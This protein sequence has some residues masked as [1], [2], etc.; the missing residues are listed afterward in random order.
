[1]HVLFFLPTLSGYRDRVRLLMEA[2][3]HL[4][5]LTLLVGRSDTELDV[6]SY[7]RFDIID[8]HVRRGWWLWNALKG[9]RRAEQLIAQQGVTIVHDTF[10]FL[11][12]LFRRKRRYPSVSFLT[13]LFVLKGWRVRNVWGHLSWSQRLLSGHGR[14]D[15]FGRWL[16]KRIC[17][18]ADRVVVQAPGLVDLLQEDVPISRDH[19]C[20][21]TNNVDV[22]FWC[23][24]EGAAR[25]N[26]QGNGVRLLCIGGFDSSRGALPVLEMLRQLRRSRQ[27][28]TITVVGTWGPFDRARLV[29]K[30]QEGG[31]EQA[32][33][34]VP[35]RSPEDLRDLY[36]SSHVLLRETINDGSPRVVLEAL[37]CGLPVVASHH[38]GIDVIDPAGDFIGFTDYGDVAQMVRLVE[39]LSSRPE[40]REARVRR[41]R[42][43]V[44]ERFSTPAAAKQYVALYEGL[45]K[46]PVRSYVL[47][48]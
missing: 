33:Q 37:A 1:M 21:L 27:E 8:L 22:D 18:A 40:D 16:E 38:P 44:V 17:L 6:S 4:D 35:R 15:L 26:T 9:S 34:F 32:I 39:H 42:A 41:G 29:R 2:S 30:V 14:Q 45:A 11:L 23:P 31:L 19:V 3:N 47:G 46:Q 36:R 43:A 28:V 25:G 24:A 13:S 10:G 5:R 12:P 7:P 20:V 48:E